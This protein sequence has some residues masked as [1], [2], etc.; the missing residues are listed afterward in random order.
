MNIRHRFGTAIVAAAILLMPGVMAGAAA[1]QSLDPACAPPAMLRDPE[2]AIAVCTKALDQPALLPPL[3]A[4]ALKTRGRAFYH[5]KRLDAAMQDFETAM[6][7]N[8]E[9]AELPVRAGGVALDRRDL[10]AVAG[11]TARAFLIDKD[12]A[13]A[14]DLVGATFYYLGNS[15][16]AEGFYEKAIAQAPSNPLPQFHLMQLYFVTARFREAVR[17]ADAILG[18]P[19]AAITEPRT[20]VFDGVYAVSMRMATENW[21][22]IFLGRMGRVEAAGDNY[23][24]AVEHDPSAF[25]YAAL[26]DYKLENGG[27]DDEAQ[28]DVGKALSLDANYWFAHQLEGQ[29]DFH[30]RRF[31]AASTEFRRAGELNP[32]KGT[33]RW[34]NARA[35]RG[36]GQWEEAAEAAAEAVRVDPGFIDSEIDTWT[37]R[38]YLRGPKPLDSQSEVV[39]DAARA[40]ILDER[41]W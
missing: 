40:C 17:Q 1:Q 22:S 37:E 9:D 8:P 15:E 11:Y 13:P 31:E 39:Q 26:A 32:T 29:I 6:L 14:T 19:E 3:R 4:E 12:F 20:I 10:V 35:L 38:G 33:L 7:V 24:H 25:T 36:L 34:W 28:K 16:R 30:A 5:L 2:L 21:R 41:C 23:R 18:L 27:P